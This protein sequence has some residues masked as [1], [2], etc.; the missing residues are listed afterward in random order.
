MVSEEEAF[1]AGL[2]LVR[3]ESYDTDGDGFPD[4]N[5]PIPWD[6][7][8]KNGDLDFESGFE[9]LRLCLAFS[10]TQELA[11]Y[12]GELV[13]IDVLGDME[14]DVLQVLE[15]DDRVTEVD[16]IT[17]EF[18]SVRKHPDDPDN[19]LYPKDEIRVDV[20]LYGEDE[21]RHEFIFPVNNN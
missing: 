19:V 17:A 9:N 21:S 13:D 7:K 1:G 12:I 5:Y 4:K 6:L 10:S 11:D 3:A 18:G 20:T 8:E 2:A 15:S 14:I 16:N